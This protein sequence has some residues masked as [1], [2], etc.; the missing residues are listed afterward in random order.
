MRRALARL[1]CIPDY[2]LIDG[3]PMPELDRPHEAMVKGDARCLSIAAASVLAKVVRDRLMER[4]APRYPVFG[5]AENKGYA[6][7]DHLA[8]IDAHGP[9]R[10]H[11]SS[12]EPVVQPRLL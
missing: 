3:T 10:H 8:A 5:W 7:A 9:C 4:L 2:I 1:R 12:F 11:R 6:T